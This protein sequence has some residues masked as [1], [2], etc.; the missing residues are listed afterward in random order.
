MKIHKF[1]L[2]ADICNILLAQVITDKSINVKIRTNG[3]RKGLYSSPEEDIVFEKYHYHQE[4]GY[5][6]YISD[7]IDSLLPDKLFEYFHLDRNSCKIEIK[8]FMPGKI[9]IPHKDYYANVTH[10]LKNDTQY[11]FDYKKPSNLDTMPIRVWIT[12]TEP[13]FGHVLLVENQALYW[14]DQ[15]TAVTWD[16]HELHTAANLG[17]EDRYIMTITGIEEC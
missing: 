7:S 3:A 2:E 17:Y 10:G 12:L 8:R 16:S 15:G 14:L 4:S 11:S 13:K 1:R 6:N 9:H 5:I